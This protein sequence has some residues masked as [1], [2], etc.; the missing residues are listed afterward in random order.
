MTVSRW[1]ARLRESSASPSAAHCPRNTDVHV[2]LPDVMHDMSQLCIASVTDS[3]SRLPIAHW[4][5]SQYIASASVAQFVPD[6]LI[7]H[8]KRKKP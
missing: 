4:H 6:V 7:A 2:K 1:A 5:Q 8:L 3:V